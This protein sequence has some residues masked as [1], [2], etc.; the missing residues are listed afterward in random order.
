MKKTGHQLFLYNLGVTDD[1]VSLTFLL[2]GIF[3]SHEKEIACSDLDNGVVYNVCGDID[4]IKDSE[5]KK[6]LME[7]G[8]HL[9]LPAITIV[10]LL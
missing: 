2:G 5:G 8:D 4:D 3:S 1:I 6:K 7:G 9:G 10:I